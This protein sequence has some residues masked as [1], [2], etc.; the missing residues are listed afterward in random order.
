MRYM[1]SFMSPAIYYISSTVIS[2]FNS[3]CWTMPTR[4]GRR[5]IRTLSGEKL[6][7]E[8]E[9]DNLD[10]TVYPSEWSKH[11]AQSRRMKQAYLWVSMNI[12]SSFFCCIILLMPHLLIISSYTRTNMS[13]KQRGAYLCLCYYLSYIQYVL[14]WVIKL[15][16][17]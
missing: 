3:D 9:D 1:I 13:V 4:K 12:L 10:I 8:S 2:Y 14:F 7:D 17:I 16:A 5:G 6:H 15:G 11:R